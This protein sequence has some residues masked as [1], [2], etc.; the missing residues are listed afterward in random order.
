MY[1]YM[2]VCMY[3]CMYIYI[4]YVCMYVCM[5]WFVIV[6]CVFVMIIYN[7]KINDDCILPF[8]Y[9]AGDECPDEWVKW[10]NNCYK[11]IKNMS[12]F[13]DAKRDCEQM[14][15]QLVSVHSGGESDFVRA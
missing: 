14:S 9:V 5:V 13:A 12:P 7:I 3:V 10:S 6:F 4:M 1:V 15:A 8:L 11:F 2:Y